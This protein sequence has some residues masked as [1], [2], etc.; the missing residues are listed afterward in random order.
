[1]SDGTSLGIEIGSAILS[2]LLDD[3]SF[4]SIT[5]PTSG[6]KARIFLLNGRDGTLLWSVKIT[7]QTDWVS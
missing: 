3:S 6:I 1:M 5:L 2:A 7:D 4:F